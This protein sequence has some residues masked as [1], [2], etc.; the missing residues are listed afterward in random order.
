M[1]RPTRDQFERLVREHH[2]AVLRAARRWCGDDAA[3]ADVAQ[4]VFLRVLAGKE[5]L[6]AAGSVR[7]TLCW[8]ATCLARNARRAERRRA[9]HEAHAMAIS[10]A[11]S[12][13]REQNADP[14]AAS[15]RA[16][17]RADLWRCVGEL[18]DDLRL[19]LLLRCQDGLTFAAIGTA[20]AVPLSTAHD[21]VE[22][23]LRRLRQ[24]LGE[25]GHAV[26]AAALPP[27]L[28][29]SA[30][31]PA[32]PGLEA[33]LLALGSTAPALPAAVLPLLAAA[34]AVLGVG[35]LLWFGAASPGDVQQPAAVV[36]LPATIA[37][38]A[39]RSAAQGTERTQVPGAATAPQAVDAASVVAAIA[40]TIHDAAAWPVAGVEVQL[41]AGGGLKPFAVSAPVLTD[42]HGAFTVV[43]DPGWLRPDAV[44]IVVREHG[45]ELLRTDDLAL[46]RPAG[47]GPLSLVLPPAAGTATQQYE[48]AV[49]VRDPEGLP[50]VGVDVAFY[51]P[52][53]PP[54][55]AGR[56]R[57]D[58]R[59]VT[60][61][62]GRAVLRGRAPGP[63]WLFVDGRSQRRISS[64]QR[65]DV[66]AG[67]QQG[68]MV[69]LAAGATLSVTLSKLDGTPLVGGVWIEDEAIGLVHNGERQ[70]DGSTQFAGLGY[71]PFTVH[72]HGDGTT[73]P[74]RRRSVRPGDGP[75]QFRLKARDDERDVGDHL[76]ELH[77]ELF[78]AA[79]GEVVEFEP[80]DL[81]VRRLVADGSSLPVDGVAAPQ[82]AAQ[83]LDA[84][85]RSTRFH[86]TG[87]DAGRWLVTASVPGYGCAGLVIE[88]REGEVRTGLRVPLQ[89]EV[90]VRGRVAAGGQP[91]A[92]ARMVVFGVGPLADR[93]LEAWQA[94]AAA[95]ERQPA[96]PS[97]TPYATTTGADGSFRLAGLPADVPL[98][99]IVHDPAA[100]ALG[101]VALPALSAGRQ[102][103]AGTVA[104]PGP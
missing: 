11:G 36:D 9:D 103:D 49:T 35:G 15:E 51:A 44:R 18:P 98:R 28:G 30:P 38:P 8:L 101:V 82:F 63:K 39:D 2:A 87:L 48:F 95:G 94:A 37:P 65:V 83:Q 70:P 47:E 42:A 24:R 27:L 21:R 17:L 81:H 66:A 53:T 13:G 3:A 92:G 19:P 88:L 72:A 100:R 20:L 84:G 99:L 97:W 41:V 25:R 73:S 69:A 54:P 10:D 31:P 67:A 59:A 40:G 102:H 74:A 104:L 68:P 80:F 14:A 12:A 22:A 55:R 56:G 43:A 57:I 86:E 91:V 78:D 60:G 32:P 52:S 34:V 23:A 62:D 71:G 50:L 85:G 61:V 16:D 26:A 75:L 96:P 64:L 5:R 79:T 33:R 4:E 89:R 76:A 77:G 58:A 93:H 29:A 45:R 46:P 90:V 1:P 6:D 7:A